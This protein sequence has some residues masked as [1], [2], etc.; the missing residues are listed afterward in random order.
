MTDTILF[1]KNIRINI[2]KMI[3]AGQS[4]HIGSCFSICDILAVLYG[5]VLR[6]DP[7]APKWTQRDRFVLSKGHAGAAV[8][9]SLAE[10]GFFPKEK[11]MEHYQN[12]SFMSGHVSHK[13]I[14]GVEL[15]T[16]SLG[17]GISV[18]IGMALRA[19]LD[20]LD[21]RVFAVLGDGECGEGSIWEGSLFAAHQKLD[22]LTIIIDYNKLQSIYSTQETLALEPFG[23]KWRS[24]GWDV[25]EIDGHD[26]TI[27]EST[28]TKTSERN[29]KPKCIIANTI[30]GKG[31]SFME[32]AVVWHYRWPR[33]DEVQRAL[34]ELNQV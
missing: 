18:G 5:K 1:A 20:N 29:N 26:H 9:A 16:G 25:F 23:D 13:N 2:L 28:F 22:N 27:L 15:S 21:Y 12:G 4:S 19:K 7:D 30:K 34:I 17:H 24:F 31:V 32:N 6:V 14:P 10:R 3:H 8:Y 11:L 33:I